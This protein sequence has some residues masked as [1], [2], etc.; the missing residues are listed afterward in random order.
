MFRC[1]EGRLHHGPLPE[2]LCPLGK[3][4]PD[5][6]S[7]VVRFGTFHSNGDRYE[8]NTCTAQT[9]KHA[10]T[11]RFV[12]QRLH[13]W[14]HLL[15]VEPTVRETPRGHTQTHTTATKT[16]TVTVSAELFMYRTIIERWEGMHVVTID[17][18]EMMH[19]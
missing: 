1:T 15:L 3:A 5:Q 6:S 16:S 18:C 4:V 19:L 11:A 2:Q 14:A 13:S 7:R 10:V 8:V 12:W 17:A 9:R